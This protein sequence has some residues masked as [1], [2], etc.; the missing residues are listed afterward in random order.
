M[1]QVLTDAP[2]PVLLFTIATA[3]TTDISTL[4]SNYGDVKNAIPADIQDGL[5]KAGHTLSGSQT[6]VI[7]SGSTSWLIKDAPN[8]YTVKKADA[9][10]NVYSV[11]AGVAGV[12]ESQS[13][14]ATGVVS[15]Q[16]VTAS[17]HAILN[18][19]FIAPTPKPTWFDD[20]NN[21]LDAAKVLAKQ[22]ID[23]LA[24]EMTAKLPNEVINYASTYDAVT[25]QIVQIASA[26]P[27]AKG[28]DNTAVQQVF[29]LIN[30][31][32]SQ[33]GTIHDDLV[34]EDGK[35]TTW[36]DAMQKA[37]DDL[38][39]GAASIQKAE[40][41]L[42]ADIG[43]MNTAIQGLQAEITAE[44]KAICAAAIAVALG[45][46]ILIVGIAVTI[47]T[48][49]AGAIVIGIGAAGII[50]GAVTWGIMQ[51]KIDTQYDEIAK[52][53][54]RIADDKRQLVAL[55]GLSM[56]S[57]QAVSAVAVATSALSSVKTM[58][59][60]FEGE[61]QGVLDKLN[62]ANQSLALIVNEAFVNGANEEWQLAED[63]AQQIVATPVKLDAKTL[64]MDSKAA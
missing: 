49:G 17:C 40:S 63:L 19:V 20:L 13:R 34:A 59:K 25:K 1:S 48:G 3:P 15:L 36:G 54:A 47:A 23:E 60:L 9:S 38:Y 26:N 57:N 50:G 58:W 52:D 16:I 8:F 29:D 61:L 22:W 30:A 35:L 31:L 64:P 55:Q 62:M 6:V 12:L 24:P 42:T 32:K 5:K 43:K 45:I 11:T 41:D 27:N 10:L 18:T 39:T 46:F 51:H 21:R 7:I 4:D 53:Q 14:M 56:A 44:N 2:S 28:K 33:V 37:H